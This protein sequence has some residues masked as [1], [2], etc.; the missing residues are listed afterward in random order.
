MDK[1]AHEL[2]EVLNRLTS[3]YRLIV[4]KEKPSAEVSPRPYP[5]LT[6]GDELRLTC[7]V[8][9]ATVAIAWKKNDD[10]VI[11][12]A[13]ID[14]GVDGRLSKLFIEGVV[15]GDSGEYSCE[16]R[17]RPGIVARSTVKINV[18]G[19]VTFPFV[20][21]PMKLKITAAYLKDFFLFIISSFFLETFRFL[22]CAMRKMITS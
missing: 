18:M 21:V 17:N 9:R 7:K 5:K 6:A 8:N 15:E 1:Y 22:Y 19:K 12:R 10:E 11:P 20:K 16:A 14:T 3:V 2:L 13:Q 4:S